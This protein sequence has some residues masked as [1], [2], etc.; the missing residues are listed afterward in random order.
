MHVDRIRNEIFDLDG[1]LL[2]MDSSH[3]DVDQ[4]IDERCDVD[5]VLWNGMEECDHDF[6]KRDS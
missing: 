1:L 4:I 2:T 6:R 5:D 3:F